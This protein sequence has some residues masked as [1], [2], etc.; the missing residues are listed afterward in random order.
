M[1]PTHERNCAKMNMLIRWKR[2]VNHLT[3]LP[4]HSFLRKEAKMTTLLK[5]LQVVRVVTYVILKIEHKL[6][7]TMFILIIVNPTKSVE[8]VCVEWDIIITEVQI[9]VI[10]DITTNIT[11][12]LPCKKITWAIQI[13]TS[14]ISCHQR[15]NK[16]HYKFQY[17]VIIYDHFAQIHIL[18]NKCN[19]KKYPDIRIIVNKSM[20]ECH[21]LTLVTNRISNSCTTS[22]ANK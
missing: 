9:I 18:I 16:H 13:M 10:I 1:W 20:I 19:K 21:Y 7:I 11:H 2:L 14:N 5:L 12:K 3:H 15:K 4:P 22:I 8:A 6:T 17:C